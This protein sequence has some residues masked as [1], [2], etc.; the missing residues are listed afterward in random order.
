[1]YRSSR[2]ALEGFSKNL[3]AAFEFRLLP[4][5]FSFNWLGIMFIE[6]LVVVF[7]KAT[8]RTIQPPFWT[9]VVWLVLSLLIWVI[10]YISLGIPAWLAFLFPAT[11]LSNGFTALR[12]L[13]LSLTGNLTWKGRRIKPTS[14]KWI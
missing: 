2:E 10:P 4:Y 1:M 5:L 8:G 9:L 12:S 11:I 3:F 13:W 6:P 14:W 7:L